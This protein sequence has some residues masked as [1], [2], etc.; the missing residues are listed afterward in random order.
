MSHPSILA[1][2]TRMTPHT[3]GC[4]GLTTL[5]L[6]TAAGCFKSVEIPVLSRRDAAGR[7]GG[8]TPVPGIADAPPS[9][10]N[11]SSSEGIC[12]RGG[13]CL[14]L[15]HPRENRADILFV[16]DNSS[17]MA[18]AQASLRS[19][20]RRLLGALTTGRRPGGST[21]FPLFGDVHLGVVSTD[22]GL[23]GDSDV[24]GC[25][26]LGGDDG[27][28]QHPGMMGPGC[29]D[30]YPRFLAFDA[31]AP[32]SELSQSARDFGC[33]ATLGTQG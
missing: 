30:S 27:W 6:L 5:V 8:G 28:L 31:T 3:A 22:M 2:L 33:M 7:D 12:V 18:L 29:V 32:V 19:T 9:Q 10:A 20:F 1:A 15:A 21:V 25:S 16:V 11:A 17:G 13:P 4:L 23:S 14:E 26:E 24:P